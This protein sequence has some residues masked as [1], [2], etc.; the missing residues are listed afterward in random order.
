LNRLVLGQLGKG[1]AG[2]PGQSLFRLAVRPGSRCK[3]PWPGAPEQP[4]SEW[5]WAGEGWC[6]RAGSEQAPAHSARGLAG[7]FWPARPAQPSRVSRKAPFAGGGLH[8]LWWSPAVPRCCGTLTV[9]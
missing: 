3:P 7:D 9:F 8:A 5:P 4:F 2:E 1:A 6:R